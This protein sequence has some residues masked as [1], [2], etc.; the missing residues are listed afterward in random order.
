M[1]EARFR[2]VCQY[3]MRALLIAV[4]SLLLN[5]SAWAQSLGASHAPYAHRVL[6]SESQIVSESRRRSDKEA[7]V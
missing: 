2:P 5:A 1:R 4:L 7:C 6:Q 3:T